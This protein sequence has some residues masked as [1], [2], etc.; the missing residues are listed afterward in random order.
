[1]A[2]AV[3]LCCCFCFCV[4]FHTLFFPLLLYV[5]SIVRFQLVCKLCA[6]AY[7]VSAAANSGR[8]LLLPITIIIILGCCCCSK[9]SRRANVRLFLVAL[10]LTLSGRQT[11]HNNS[12][13]V[14]KQQQQH[15]GHIKSIQRERG[16]CNSNIALSLFVSEALTPHTHTHPI[17][18]VHLALLVC[19]VTNIQRQ[20]Q[21]QQLISSSVHS[22]IS[23]TRKHCCC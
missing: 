7:A 17:H 21:Q 9:L 6:S 2:A 16:L 1:M 22:L 8:P 19:L 13:K 23:A 3:T 15:K 5:K 10:S 18:L 12:S 20:Q 14:H 11:Q 4:F